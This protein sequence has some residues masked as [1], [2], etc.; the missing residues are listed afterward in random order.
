MLQVQR[1]FETKPCIE[2]NHLVR[3]NAIIEGNPWYDVS[4]IKDVEKFTR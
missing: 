3:Y 2:M 4:N 1:K